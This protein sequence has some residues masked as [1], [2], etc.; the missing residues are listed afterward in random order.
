MP[1][2]VSGTSVVRD[3]MPGQPP[4]CETSLCPR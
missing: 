4:V 2:F 1:N 3:T